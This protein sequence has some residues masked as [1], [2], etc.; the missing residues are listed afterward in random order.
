MNS[1]WT[2]VDG[3]FEVTVPKAGRYRLLL[4]GSALP[5]RGGATTVDLGLAGEVDGVLPGAVDVVIRAVPVVRDLTQEVSVIDADGRPLTGAIVSATWSDSIGRSADLRTD[6]RGRLTMTGLPG[7]ACWFT[8]SS[9]D[10]KDEW[11][12]ASRRVTI[13]AS[14]AVELRLRRGTRIQGHVLIPDGVAMPVR[15]DVRQRKSDGIERRTVEVTDVR[16]PTFSV[17]LDPEDGVLTGVEATAGPAEA[18]THRARAEGSA[19]AA[20]EIVLTLA[21]VK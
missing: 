11:L 6:A 8:A 5:T 20:G 7:R 13:P 18:P 9:A 15:I 4:D 12:D 19:L 14:G 17:L 10:A 21:P 16:A 2:D 1:T 3:G